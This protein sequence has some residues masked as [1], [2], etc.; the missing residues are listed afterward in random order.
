MMLQRQKICVFAGSSTP[1]DKSI[2]DAAEKLGAKIAAAGYDLVYG[3]GTNGVMGAVA[4]AVRRAGADVTAV[5]L[6]KYSYE[7]QADG[8]KVDMV[9]TEA[10][11]FK[12]FLS[13]SPAAYFVLP[14][15]PGALREALQGL[16]EAVYGAGAP[17]ILVKV[18]AYLDGIQQYFD[19]AVAAGMIRAAKKDCLKTWSVDEDLS[20]VLTKP[21]SPLL[22]LSPKNP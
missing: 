6:E 11:R 16:E 7:A 10:D 4:K 17:V 19:L 9:E 1:A 18:G 13:L 12:F 8:A 21:A 2:L 14:G 22:P 3:G 15:G 5:T 20:A